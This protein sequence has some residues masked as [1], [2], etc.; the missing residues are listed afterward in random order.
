MQDTG[1]IKKRLLATTYKNHFKTGDHL[2]KNDKK[3]MHSQ[4][5]KPLQNYRCFSKSID[6]IAEFIDYA[7]DNLQ[8]FEIIRSE[9]DAALKLNFRCSFSLDD[10][11]TYFN[12]T[13]TIL[14]FQSLKIIEKPVN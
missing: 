9:K 11:H 7:G 12:R 10:L 6:L 4:E 2:G 5:L 14:M 8:S 1:K 3:Y 13:D